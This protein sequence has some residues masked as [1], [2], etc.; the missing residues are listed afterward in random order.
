MAELT[1]TARPYARAAFELARAEALLDAWAQALNVLSAVCGDHKIAGLIHSPTLTAAGKCE[2]LK[3]LCGDALSTKQ[4]NFVQTLAD[5]KRL[6]LL[7]EINRL[8]LAFK[9]E[10]DKT[11]DVEVST[12]FEMGAEWQAKLAA[13][14]STKLECKVSLSTHLD[15]SLLG[16]AV[17]RAGDTVI[18]GSVRGRLAKLA[19]AMHA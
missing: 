4:Q 7:P 1:T 19:D 9:A 18:D 2:L 15:K 17:I 11:L 3:N 6:S 5:N 16:G 12:A 13:A 10:H 14:L 8:F